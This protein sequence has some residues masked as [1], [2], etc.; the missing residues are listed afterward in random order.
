MDFGYSRMPIHAGLF[1]GEWHLTQVLGLLQLAFTIWMLVDAYRSGVETYWY[2]IIFFFQP[3]GAWAYFFAVKL[4]TLRFSSR[5][6]VRSGQSKLSLDQ[7]R[8][9]VERSPTVA[10]RLALAERLMDRG[11]HGEAIP[12]LEAVLKVEPD[13]CMALHDLAECKLATGN[14]EQSVEPLDRLLRR[15]PCWADYRAWRT[16]IEVHR[17]RG[18]LADALAACR[19]FTKRLPT[20]ENK[21]R[22][23]EQLLDNG[24]ASEAVQLLDDAIEEQQLAPWSRRWHNWRWSRLANR[25]LVE[26]EKA[27]TAREAAPPVHDRAGSSADRPGE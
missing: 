26:A 4:R 1:G 5:R 8:Y 2:L 22:L 12:L 13:Y 18:Q 11:A 14:P 3:I 15:D 10:N 19:E 21:C 25:L 16:L 17:A 27:E 20:L 7:L 6:P 24:K 9:L 23:A